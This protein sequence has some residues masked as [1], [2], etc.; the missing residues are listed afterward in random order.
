[1]FKQISFFTLLAV[2]MTQLF[3]AVNTLAYTS[4][5]T[6][7][8]FSTHLFPSSSIEGLSQFKSTIDGI[9]SM[10][11]N[12]PHVRFQLEDVELFPRTDLTRFDIDCN[13]KAPV[14][15]NPTNLAIVD[16]ALEY[17]QDSGVSVYVV[18]V[19][20]YWASNFSQPDQ[21][22]ESA[23]TDEEY[24]IL[25]RQYLDVVVSRWAD[26]VAYW[27]I[28]NE[29]NTQT[30][31]N[32]RAIDFANNNTYKNKL[33]KAISYIGNYF[34]QY[35][36]SEN[37][38]VN[39][40]GYPVNQNTVEDMEYFFNS[41]GDNVDMFG[42]DW[43]PDGNPTTIQ[44]IPAYIDYLRSSTNKPIVVPEVGMCVDMDR[45]DEQDQAVYLPLYFE[46]LITAQTQLAIAYNYKDRSHINNK[47]EASF[48][49]V[50]SDGSYRP[51]KQALVATMQKQQ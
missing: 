17:A 35:Y 19:V 41:V 4:S 48:G 7:M 49:I 44:N 29:A 3:F 45:F 32:Y 21:P 5:T 51:A 30:Y 18:L 6:A 37:T 20:P 2:G 34:D 15:C 26:K 1:M 40:A 12:S 39:A 46:K 36:P 28:F 43:Y 10:D 42:A 13:I 27:Q 38:V 22:W 25:I 23:F 50:R 14:N 24:Q 11:I 16:Q 33:Q 31:D 9:V 47:C 8:G